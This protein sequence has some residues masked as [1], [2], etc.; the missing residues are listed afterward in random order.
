M[1]RVRD[2]A[3]ILTASSVL[4]TDVEV[5]TA[6]SDHSAA[7][8][9]HTGYVLESLIDA[10]GDLIVGSADN[11]VAKLTTGSNG[12]TLVADNSTSTGLRYTAGTVQAN[13]VIN[14]C[15]D[16]WQRGTSLT[17]TA[18]DYDYTADRWFSFTYSVTSGK[19]VSRQATG[20]TT[21]LPNIQYCARVQRN[22]GDTNTSSWQFFNPWETANS[23]PFAGKTVTVSFYA[24]KGANY[25]A[26]SSLLR[27]ILQSGNGTDQNPIVGYT[28]GGDLIDQSPTLTTTWQRFTYT[29]AVP[30]TVTE[31]CTLFLYTPTGTAGAADYYEVTGVQMDIGSVALPVRRNA[32]TIQGELAACQRYYEMHDYSATNSEVLLMGA[33]NTST[34]FAR[35][36]WFV[37]KRATPSIVIGAA[38]NFVYYAGGLNPSSLAA[39]T[40]I[41]TISARIDVNGTFTAGYSYDLR[42]GAAGS[43]IQI[44]AEL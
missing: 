9:P 14:S 24:R 12:D 6:V 20:D 27:F 33:F 22:N 32:A 17:T 1:S 3:S 35:Y 29:V 25:S 36:T 11:T 26:T 38:S 34:C 39:G 28:G 19:T 30:A 15:F 4:G 5:A 31:M 18:I 10:K 44:S 23:I 16:I 21:N 8:D 2:L 13:P 42:G 41:N 40:G 37:P 43:T 7:S